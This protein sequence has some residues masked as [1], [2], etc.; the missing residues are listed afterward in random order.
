ME[1]FFPK[2]AIIAKSRYSNSAENAADVILEHRSIIQDSGE[3]LISRNSGRRILVTLQD[4][5]G[6]KLSNMEKFFPRAAI[7]AKSRYSNSA[8]NA[9]DV[10]PEH[11]SI[12]QDSG[13]ALIS[14]HSV[15]R[16]LIPLQISKDFQIWFPNAAVQNHSLWFQTKTLLTEQF[17]PKSAIIAKSRYFNSAENAADVILERRSIIQDSGEALISRNSGKLL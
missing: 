15:R 4:S 8:E 11:R 6:P 12:I 2:A 7:I 3:A 17:F 16:I 9:A 13:E 14:R 5:K 1:Q 10:I